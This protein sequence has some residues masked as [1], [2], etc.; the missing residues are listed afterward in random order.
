LNRNLFF[1]NRQTKRTYQRGKTSRRP[2][3]TGSPCW[4]E[5]SSACDLNK[6]AYLLCWQINKKWCNLL[7][8]L[9]NFFDFKLFWYLLIMSV[10]CIMYSINISQWLTGVVDTDVVVA[11]Q[12]DG[13][14]EAHRVVEGELGDPDVARRQ[15]DLRGALVLVRRPLQELVLPVLQLIINY[16]KCLIINTMT[17]IIMYRNI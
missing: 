10:F 3:C 4:T 7:R 8:A 9:D 17:Y 2:S 14:V 13:V 1:V 15:E 16:Y 12:L 6:Q 11:L 5:C